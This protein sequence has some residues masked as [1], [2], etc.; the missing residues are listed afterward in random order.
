MGD[1][2]PRTITHGHIVISVGRK[3]FKCRPKGCVDSWNDTEYRL[4]TW[5]SNSG[6]GDRVYVSEQ[7]I[8]DEDEAIVICRTIEE[9]FRFCNVPGHLDLSTLR[10]ITELMESND[11]TKQNGP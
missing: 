3:Y 11:V 8:K 10:K 4:D 5:R 9:M 6:S 2:Q 1:R 7:A